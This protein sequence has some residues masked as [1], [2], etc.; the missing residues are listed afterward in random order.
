MT[1]YLRL[2]DYSRYPQPCYKRLGPDTCLTKLPDFKQGHT[3]RLRLA[4][5]S[6]DE[7][8]WP[9]FVV[10]RPI[11]E[12]VIADPA[13]PGKAAVLVE[14]FVVLLSEYEQFVEPFQAWELN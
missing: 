9:E 4:G 5:L 6:D 10:V 12:Q 2:M 8:S 14:V 3:Y 11:Q 7:S 13:R 1:Y